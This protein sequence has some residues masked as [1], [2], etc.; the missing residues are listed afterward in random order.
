MGLHLALGAVE[1]EA[2]RE[3]KGIYVV[4][5][6]LPGVINEALAEVEL[7]DLDLNFNDLLSKS[8]LCC[9][10]DH[11]HCRETSS[12]KLLLLLIVI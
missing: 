7:C 1:F 8:L 3:E 2:S 5:E 10:F 12:H 9:F 11:Y 4:L 6:V